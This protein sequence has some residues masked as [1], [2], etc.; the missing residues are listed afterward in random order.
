M[1]SPLFLI[2]V[3]E[4]GSAPHRKPPG[5][6]ATKGNAPVVEQ[7]TVQMTSLCIIVFQVVVFVLFVRLKLIF[8]RLRFVAVALYTP[9]TVFLN[10]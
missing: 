1:A 2:C 8:L 3:A 9:E 7:E 4:D 6:A 10:I 5:R